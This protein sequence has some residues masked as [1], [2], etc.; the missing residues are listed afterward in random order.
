MLEVLENQGRSCSMTPV[1]PPHCG[2]SPGPVVGPLDGALL[3]SDRL[4]KTE[5]N[6]KKPDGGLPRC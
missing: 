6:V 1:E 3:A 5:D 4:E 2:P